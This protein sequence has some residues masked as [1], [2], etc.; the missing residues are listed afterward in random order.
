MTKEE[1]K[2]ILSRNKEILEKYKVNSI[3]LFGSYVRNEQRQDSDIDLLVEL[4][5][6]TYDNFIHLVFTLEE[7]LKKKINLVPRGSLSP[8]IEP[9]VEKEAEWIETR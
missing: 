5:E 4:E 1:V 2:Q 8:Y 9:Y 7:L 6:P 3:A